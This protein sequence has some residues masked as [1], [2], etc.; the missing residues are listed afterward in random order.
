MMEEKIKCPRCGFEQPPTADCRK[1]QVNIPKYIEIRKRR[2]IVPGKLRGRD[3]TARPEAKDI[4]K[5]GEGIPSKEPAAAPRLETAGEMS[6][7]GDLFGRSWEMFKSRFGTL[8]VLYLF[9]GL[10]L[11]IPLALFFGSGYLFSLV[12]ADSGRFLVGIGGFIGGAIGLIGMTWGF[13]AFIHAIVDET[14]GIGD[15]LRRAWRS[16][17]SF[18]WLFTLWS[19]IVGGGFLLLIIPGIIFSVWF[20]FSQFILAE[21][22][23]RGMNAL[24]KSKEY[25]RGL[26]FDIFLRLFVVWLISAVIGMVPLIGFILSILLMPFMMIFVYLIYLDMKDLK[27]DVDY[28]SSSGEKTKWL[29]AAALGYVVAPL[30]VIGILGT[31]FMTSLFLLSNILKSKDQS[32]TIPFQ[33]PGLAPSKPDE[34]PYPQGPESAPGTTRETGQMALPAEEERPRDVMVYI[35][36]L[37]YKGSVRL[38]GDELYEIKGE[39]DMNYN[40][41]GGGKFRYG[42]NVI[43]VDYAS[44]PNSWK[45]ELKIKVYKYDWNTGKETVL[46]EW[47]MTD[48]GGRK[49]FQVAI[50]R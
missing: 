39:Q 42:E 41:S 12:L 19:F 11:A 33:P 22:D 8:I 23:V 9:S 10:F 47:V 45:T 24:L 37:N 29:G 46:E 13:A 30:I 31:T 14:L 3:E 20:A 36:S 16:V 50:S 7:I 49:S 48:K 44:L 32:T 6:G 38:N 1:C 18:I 34:T 2:H 17:G 25:V 15:S 21:E 26:W 5:P 40:F 27:G 28:V 43:D 4:P 35:Y